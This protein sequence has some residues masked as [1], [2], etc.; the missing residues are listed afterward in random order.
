MTLEV[1]PDPPSADQ[2]EKV[3][4]DLKQNIATGLLLSDPAARGNLDASTSRRLEVLH[5]QWREA[6]ALVAIL[7]D[8]VGARVSHTDLAEVSRVCVDAARARDEV[9]LEVTGGEHVVSGD[10]VLLRRAVSNLLDNACRATPPNG[11]VT[12]RVGTQGPEV[13]VEVADEGPGFGKISSGSGL[14]LE[15]ARAAVWACGGQLRIDT[16]PRSGT[17]IRMTFPAALRALP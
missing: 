4:H 10:R 5:Q 9:M 11:Q 6:A 17:S 3:C 13:W 8:D 2:F 16:G 1:I 15:I 14:G 7:N 12:V